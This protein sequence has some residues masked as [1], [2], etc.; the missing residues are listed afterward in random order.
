MGVISC[1]H[2]LPGGR[3]D[4]A[5]TNGGQQVIAHCRS[6]Q[7]SLEGPQV[8]DLESNVVQPRFVL[9]NE[10]LLGALLTFRRGKKYGRSGPGM[11]S[12][13]LAVRTHKSM[14]REIES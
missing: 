9:H 14:E 3:P 2:Y 5:S 1:A 11:M 7:R 12:L 4:P 8:H 13:L 10:E 6:S